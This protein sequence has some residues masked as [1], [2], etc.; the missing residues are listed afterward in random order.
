[1]PDNKNMD[2]DNEFNRPGQGQSGQKEGQQP[3][4]PQRDTGLPRQD[5]DEKKSD[6]DISRDVDVRE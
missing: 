3:Q 4:Q 6:S 5:E 1:M 2:R